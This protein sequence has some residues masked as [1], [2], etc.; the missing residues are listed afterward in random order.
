TFAYAERLA[1]G[2]EIRTLE[3]DF[4]DQTSSVGME[5]T[6]LHTYHAA[7]H[8]GP[9]AIASDLLFLHGAAA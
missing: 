8:G 2:V 6:R 4:T 7:G 1:S 9:L 3:V 5:R